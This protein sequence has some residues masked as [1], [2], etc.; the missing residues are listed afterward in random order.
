[1]FLLSWFFILLFDHIVDGRAQQG[2]RG[3]Q[4]NLEQF[5]SGLLAVILIHPTVVQA[6]R[7]S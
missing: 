3:R 5:L 7:N 6:C 4:K 1:M 2:C